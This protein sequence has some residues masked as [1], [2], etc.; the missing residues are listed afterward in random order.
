MDCPGLYYLLQQAGLS[1]ARANAG[2][3][4]IVIIPGNLRNTQT[5]C[6]PSAKAVSPGSPISPRAGS[7]VLERCANRAWVA[8]ALTL[9]LLFAGG[10]AGQ[11]QYPVSVDARQE[12]TSH[13]ITVRNDGRVPLQIQL[14][15]AQSDNLASSRSWPIDL[16]LPAGQ[17]AEVA[18]VR[19]LDAGRSYRFSYRYSILLGDP[20]AQPDAAAR[21]RV[22]FGSGRAYRVSQAPDG[23]IV[24]HNDPQTAN[25]LDLVMPEG[26]SV[27]A[28]RAGL[29][30]EVF[31]PSA[32]R[33]DLAGRGTYVRIFHDDG[34]WADYA[35]LSQPA[36]SLALNARIEAGAPIGLSGNT[37]QS[38]GPHLHFHVQ[39]NEGGKIISIPVVFSTPSRS[40]VRPAQGEMLSGD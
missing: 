12:G 7:A 24:T 10:A 11:S 26:T 4:T 18:R 9:L 2:V 32:T 5:P 30:L 17:T 1:S 34:T 36:P 33:A 21:Y 25:A 28:A 27:L 3:A 13:R 8:S 19:P 37:G 39:R 29:V 16:V 35:H 6:A 38:S 22:P 31:Q 23:I 40:V 20:H 15:L 14:S